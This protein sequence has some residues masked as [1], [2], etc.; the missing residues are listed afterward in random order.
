MKLYVSRSKLSGEIAVPGSKSHTIRAIAI[1]SLAK[2]ASIIKAPL[3]SD[4]TV[5]SLTAASTLGAWV[6]RGDDSIWRISGTNGNL[7]ETAGSVDLGNSGTGVKLLASI[8]SLASFPVT[9]DGDE[10]LRSRPMQ[11]LLDAL[12]LVGVRCTSQNGRCP[13]TVHGP[14]AGGETIVEGKSSQYLSALLLAAPL[15]K[16][17]TTIIVHDL[18][19]IPY[20]DI[21][22]DWLKRQEIDVKHDAN[23]TRF[24]VRGRQSYR[25]FTGA[26][27]GDFSS[28][29]FPLVAAAV[30]GGKVVL[31]NLDFS[32][33]QGDKAV[34]GYLEKMGA[35]IDISQD[36]VAVKSGRLK[37]VEL[38]LNATPD[39]LP[40]MCVAAACAEGRSVFRNVAQARI[41]ETDR[42]S[43]MAAEL[44]R[45][46]IKVEEFEDGLAVTGSPLTAAKVDSHK[47]HRIAMSLAIAGLVAQA[48]GS[49]SDVTEIDD[50]ECIA[51]TYPAFV[52]DFR[53]LGAAF[54]ES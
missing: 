47:D 4:D 12:S 32:D 52:E 29:A 51:V 38:D 26:I 42:I 53:N 37:A 40:V 22:L 35:S 24:I 17:D 50:S 46:G 7:I 45:M 27:P 21:T 33:A 23:Y 30:T 39:A 15:A 31:R 54:Y 28:G 20:V 36:R 10:S 44:G 49:G 2:G 9:F 1:A 5:S 34:F 13:F 14:F 48:D 16:S 25:S 6:K 19:E 11:P 41:K 18:N 43:C 8:A 3:V